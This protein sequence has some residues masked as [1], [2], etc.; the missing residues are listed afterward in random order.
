MCPQLT[1]R[2]REQVRVQVDV[3]A[4]CHAHS[5]HLGATDEL[6]ILPVWTSSKRDAIEESERR[7][8]ENLQRSTPRISSADDNDVA[9]R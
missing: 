9:L 2:L 6:R 5:M 3:R 1:R 8:G 4:L 7:R